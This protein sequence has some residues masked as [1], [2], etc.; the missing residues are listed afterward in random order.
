MAERTAQTESSRDTFAWC[1]VWGTVVY[2]LL[3][4]WLNL[5]PGW[6][7]FGFGF[8]LPLAFGALSLWLA[9][10]SSSKA[11]ER[12]GPEMQLPGMPKPHVPSAQA[13][14]FNRALGAGRA[15]LEGANLSGTKTR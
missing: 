3:H 10:K 9:H 2:A 12:M 6:L 15:S 1:F 7:S 14:A 4:S 5:A 8:S 13:S 11:P